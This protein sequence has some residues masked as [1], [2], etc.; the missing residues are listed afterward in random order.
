MNNPLRTLRRSALLQAIA[1]CVL[2]PSFVMLPTNVH[3][4]PQGGVVVAGAAEILQG[5]DFDPAFLEIL[6]SSDKAIIN[7]EDF[8]IGE[9]ETTR[10]NVPG[11]TSATLNR[12]ISGNP[13]AIY[14]N[15]ISNGKLILVNQNGIVVGPGGAIDAFGGFI[16][17]TLDINDGDFLNGGDDVFSGSSV[18]GVTNFGSIVS[19]GGDVILLGNF[20]DNQGTIGAVDGT[21]ALGAGGDILVSQAG[22]AKI[23]IRAAGPGGDVGINNSGDIRGGSV[24]LKAHGNVYAQAINNSGMIRAS[25]ATTNANGRVIL[26]ARSADGSGGS[27]VNTGEVRANNADGS[28]GFIM[29][30]AG[31]DGGIADIDGVVKANGIGNTPGGSITILGETIGFGPNADVAANGSEGGAVIIGSADETTSVSAAPGSSIT[32]N[33]SV[34]NGGT[35]IVS[36]NNDSVISLDGTIEARGAQTGGLVAV[37]G[38]SVSVGATGM[39][40]ASGGVDGG[41]VNVDATNG[42]AT[43]NGTIL[44]DGATGNGGFVSVK[45]S[46]GVTVGPNALISASGEVNGGT[47][48]IEATDGEASISGTVNANGATGNGGV[49]T[50]KGADGVTLSSTGSLNA[51]GGTNGGVITVDGGNGTAT[52]NGQINANGTTGNGGQVIIDAEGGTNIGTGAQINANGGTNGGVIDVDS[53]GDTVIGGGATLSATGG[54]GAGGRITVSGQDVTLMA[55]P[56]NLNVNGATGAGELAVGGSFQGV[57]TLR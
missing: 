13:S 26:T 57:S 8:S 23:S 53:G 20:I 28:G 45:G 7:W 1:L 4:N 34:G 49:I 46:D 9:G 30:D 11:V 29:V 52:V 48:L 27:I 43:I 25:G 31:G 14:G 42:V 47:V 6:Q 12:V 33:G 51:N 44:A 18:A 24:E 40:D 22:E 54:S 36:G 35:V 55:G 41:F 16:G 38:G 5:E 50:V 17:S 56:T 39:I 32:A 3:A 37:T 2:L 15:L 19:G 10:F 21:I